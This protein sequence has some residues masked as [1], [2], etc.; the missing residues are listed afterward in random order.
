MTR[1]SRERQA[2]RRPRSRGPFSD[3]EFDFSLSFDD[4]LTPTPLKPYMNDS[5]FG[6]L[7]FAGALAV[8]GVTMN[9]T[10]RTT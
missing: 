4:M 5:T 2:L 10:R 7:L 3:V 1:R 9:R 8:A 6:T